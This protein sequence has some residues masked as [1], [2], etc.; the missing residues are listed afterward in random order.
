LYSSSSSSRARIN[1]L[2]HPWNGFL[3]AESRTA[4]GAL[5]LG[6]GDD[7]SE[8]VMEEVR[9]GV[10]VGEDDV[11]ILVWFGLVWCVVVF[12]VGGLWWWWW[13]LRVVYA[14]D[15]DVMVM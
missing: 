5:L 7:G 3:N 10:W 2:D 11:D 1:S 13:W 12:L 4:A 14:G 15:G 9:E 8:R 6:A